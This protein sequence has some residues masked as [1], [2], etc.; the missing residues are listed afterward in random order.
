MRGNPVAI[1][2]IAVAYP[3]DLGFHGS[4]VPYAPTVQRG[5]VRLEPELASVRYMPARRMPSGR[6]ATRR[7]GGRQA[8]C[9]RRLEQVAEAVSA[10]GPSPA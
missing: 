9:G 10:T 4:L 6:T 3:S 8:D 2:R 7:R 1:H 5:Q